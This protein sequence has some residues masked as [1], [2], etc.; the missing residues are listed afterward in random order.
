MCKN[1][2][3]TSFL[4][5]ARSPPAPFLLKGPDFFYS[6]GA[7]QVTKCHSF[8][9]GKN[10]PEQDTLPF[11]ASSR[12][13]NNSSSSDSDSIS[14][15]NNILHRHHCVE[16][17][18]QEGNERKILIHWLLLLLLRACVCVSLCVSKALMPKR[19]MILAPFS[20][21][22]ID[23]RGQVYNN[24]RRRVTQKGGYFLS[25]KVAIHYPRPQFL[26]VYR[27][28]KWICVYLIVYLTAGIQK[29]F[30]RL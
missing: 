5:P 16:I 1:S 19:K 12:N 29:V 17:G 22:N 6:R 30:Y 9:D 15:S 24:Q 3:K 2:K 25:G 18:G 26:L 20:L 23:P 4:A 13:D 28:C 8:H 7:K 21:C 11:C 14:S 27:L 10:P